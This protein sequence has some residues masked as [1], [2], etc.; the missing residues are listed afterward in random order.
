MN[1]K[2]MSFLLAGLL[3]ILVIGIFLVLWFGTSLLRKESQKLIDLKLENTLLEEQQSALSKA[4]KDLEDYRELQTI[5]QTIVPQD[6]DQ[7][8]AVREIIKYGDE[9]G[10]RIES[11]GFPSSSLGDT[12]SSSNKTE[13]PVSQAVPVEGISGIYSMSINVK[14]DQNTNFSYYQMLS[15]LEKLEKNRRTSHVTRVVVKPDASGQDKLNFE[16]EL[17]VYIKP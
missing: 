4:S 6:K 16:L 14:P 15:F 7:A 9:T 10:I 13:S 1:S 8:R 2:R 5:A 17:N 11:I 3:F 12:G